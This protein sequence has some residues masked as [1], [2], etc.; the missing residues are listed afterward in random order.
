MAIEPAP[1][2]YSA[3]ELL[4]AA[5]AADH[6]Q[7]AVRP[8]LPLGAKPVWGDDD[9]QKTRDPNRAQDR[10]GSKDP[11]RWPPPRF[12][13][14]DHL[15]LT[16]Q[17]GDDVQLRQQVTGSNAGSGR[18]ELLDPV[19]SLIGTEHGTAGGANAASAEKPYRFLLEV[20]WRE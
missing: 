19:R 12:G 14:H 6:R 9:G 4:F 5:R 17:R 18:A 7:S 3:G 8:Q 13:H 1:P 20:Q 15:G 16:P 2:K 10:N 11:P